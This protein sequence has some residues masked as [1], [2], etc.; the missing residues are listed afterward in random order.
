MTPLRVTA[1]DVLCVLVF[2]LVGLRSHESLTAGAV[3][4]TLWPFLLALVVSEV[5]VRVWRSPRL[6]PSGLVVW[7]TTWVGG[8][9][10]R[11]LLTEDTARLPFVVVTA[12]TLAVLLLGW[13]L[14]ATA[15]DRRAPRRAAA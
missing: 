11:L 9:L 15:V 1:A 3:L 8:L 10:L 5:L 14:V 12:L 6:L 13:R 4:G 2:V 7:G